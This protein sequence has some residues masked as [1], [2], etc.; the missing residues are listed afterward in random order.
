MEVQPPSRYSGTAINGWARGPFVFVADIRGA[1][2]RVFSGNLTVESGQTLTED[3]FVYAGNVHLMSGATIKGNLVVYSGNVAVDEGGEIDGDVTAF[4]G[5][6]MIAGQVTGNV[7][8]WSGDVSIKPSAR[9]G[10]DIS[11]LSGE[12]VRD[13]GAEVSGDVIRG[14][15]LKLPSNPLNP[16]A[17]PAFN[18]TPPVAPRATAFGQRL[19]GLIVRVLGALLLTLLAALVA[20]VFVYVRPDVV[21]GIRRNIRSE[22][23]YSFLLGLIA[24]LVLLFLSFLLTVTVCLAPL[25]L[26]PVLAFVLLNIA[27]WVAISAI[28]GERLLLAARLRW[29][30]S[31]AAAAGAVVATGIVSFLWAVGGCFRFISFVLILVV[32]SIGLGAVII[33][34]LRKATA[35]RQPR[36]P[37]AAGAVTD[38]AAPPAYDRETAAAET[39]EPVAEAIPATE[40]APD[41]TVEP[42]APE[43]AIEEAPGSYETPDV[44]SAPDDDDFTRIRGI[45]PVFAARLRQANVLTFGDLAALTPEQIAE[46]IGWPAER[47]MRTEIVEQAAELAKSG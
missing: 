32:A 39:V 44:T 1:D 23:V 43:T 25:A 26:L 10:G 29:E 30:P 20:G 9:V 15:N 4:S 13:P 38:P 27:G 24:N 18:R 37:E 21:N 5:S 11:V 7:A 40:S 46:I 2:S 28:V 41:K 47:V 14:P 42:G 45:G 19:V 34:W 31:V 36:T 33:P 16:P 12:I 17:P 6:T 22:T 35:E 8:S 3:V